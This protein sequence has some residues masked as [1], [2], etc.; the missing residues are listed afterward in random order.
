MIQPINNDIEALL[1][2]AKKG[3]D[4]DALDAVIGYMA[5]C[6]QRIAA[7]LKKR[8]PTVA[9]HEETG[10]LFQVALLKLFQQYRD[11]PGKIPD[12]SA[13]LRVHV[14][15][16][17]HDVCI[18]RTRKHKGKKASVWKNLDPIPTEQVKDETS[19]SDRAMRQEEKER[20][21]QA[22]EDLP[23]KLQEVVMQ[24]YSEGMTCRAIADIHKVNEKTVRRWLVEARDRM[25]SCLA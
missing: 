7:R 24:Y 14:V 4:P 20:V 10:D 9:A 22:L 3:G 19:V 17:F 21:Y 16:A 18:D 8:Y 5:T 11:E 6:F 2:R 25:A 13:R 12:G 1:I 23:A 15:R